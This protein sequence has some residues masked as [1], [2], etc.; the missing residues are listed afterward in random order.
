MYSE[1]RYNKLFDAASSPKSIDCGR[2]TI[3]LFPKFCKA[4][5]AGIK[6]VN[7]WDRREKKTLYRKGYCGEKCRESGPREETTFIPIAK[8]PHAPS[9]AIVETMEDMAFAA[10]E[11]QRKNSEMSMSSIVKSVDESFHF[12]SEKLAYLESCTGMAW[13]KSKFYYWLGK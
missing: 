6:R 10:L 12:L 2:G 5:G 3:Y 8:T 7:R 11:L 4:C 13:G 1:E 9:R